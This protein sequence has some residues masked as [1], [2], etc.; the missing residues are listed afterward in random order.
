MS[1]K[2]K[3]HNPEGVYPCEIKSKILTRSIIPPGLPRGINQR[4][5]AERYSTGFTPWNKS[6][7]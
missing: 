3:F 6:K 1:R 4:F 2:Y 7:I 5:N